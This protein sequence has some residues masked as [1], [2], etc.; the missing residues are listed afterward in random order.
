MA[1]IMDQLGALGVIPVVAI[2]SAGDAGALG[3]ALVGGGLP[4]AEV[5]FRTAAA[6]AAIAA[7]AGRGDMLVGAGT[8]LNVETAKR[9]QGAGARFIVSPGLNSKVVDWCLQHDLPITPGVAT[10]TEIEMALEHGLQVVKF[11]PAEAVG[12]LKTLKAFAA[13]YGM[14]R[15]IPTGGIGPENLADYLSFK[16]VL[17]CGGSWMVSRELL[18]GRQ[19]SR[20]SE[21]TK[22]AVAAVRAVRG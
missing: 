8:V 3:E 5:T 6:E 11:F 18:A 22:Q 16:P 20:V 2:D 17:A 15:F 13:P 10:P 1:E 4:V 14:V 7:L 19:W 9:A 12:G 21:L